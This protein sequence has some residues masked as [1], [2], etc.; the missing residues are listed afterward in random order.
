MGWKQKLEVPS[1]LT[2]DDPLLRFGHVTR[3]TE[4]KKHQKHNFPLESRR[5]RKKKKKEKTHNS[6][7]PAIITSK[8][9]SAALTRRPTDVALHLGAAMERRSDQV[10]LFLPRHR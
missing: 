6:L 1:S 8:A 2:L 10:H 4:K 9:K 3:Q 5:R 7:Q